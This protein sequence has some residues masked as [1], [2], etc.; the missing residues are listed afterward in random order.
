MRIGQP[1][2]GGRK[3][4]AFHEDAGLFQQIGDGLGGLSSDT[5]PILD[6][7]SFEVNLLVGVL[8]EGVVQSELF[9]DPAVAWGPGINGVQP[10]ARQVPSAGSF[11]P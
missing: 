7:F 4:L 1:W 10:V 8:L 6:A 5:D 3:K 11:Q 2:R 9:D